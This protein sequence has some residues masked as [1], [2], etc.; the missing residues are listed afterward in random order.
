MAPPVAHRGVQPVADR[1]PRSSGSLVDFARDPIACMRRLYE[2]HG[3]LAVLEEGSQRLVFVFSPEL[4]QQVLSDPD[5]FYAHFFAIRGPK[6]SSQRKLTTGLL[7][8]NGEQHKRNRRLVKE[9]FS[10]RSLLT[11]YQRIAAIADDMLDAW[12]VGQTR[13]LF[14][15]MTHYML[16]VTSTILFGFD[17]ADMAV[18]IGKKIERWAAMQHDLGIGA[19]VPDDR[20]SKGYEELLEYAKEL[21]GDILEMIRLRRSE[22]ADG[23]DVLSIL[24]RTFDDQGG[25]SDDELVGQSAVLFAA[26]HMTTAHSLTWTLFLLAQHP[27]IMQE[28][29]RELAQS[30]VAQFARAEVGG[31]SST[32]LDRV[33]K[34]S[35][36]ILP[37]S[38][39]SQRVN[40]RAVRLGSLELKRGT[41]IIWSPYI[42]HHR[43]DLYPS[44]ERFLPS[45][46]ETIRPSA[47]EYL[48]FGG[49]PR[50]CIGGPL[51]M[52]VLKTTLPRVLLRYRL[53]IE[54][55]AEINGRVISTMLTP[56]TPVPTQIHA[57][58]GNYVASPIRGN[59]HEMV[60][61]SA[62]CG[63]RV[64]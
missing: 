25:L 15:E 46:W 16:R 20:F 35:M 6:R 36:R 29:A 55:G 12:R 9:P 32:L 1:E 24:V 3:D 47:Y 26:A 5:T 45:R 48:P 18:R 64:N 60:E 28:L 37:A 41:A 62:E 14:V 44:P 61:L 57:P 56:T 63:V 43:V 39:Y 10:K 21:E 51:A 27:Q 50:L 7:G 31:E 38:S 17:R 40:E 59:I 4:N 54:P 2:E 33:I 13:D 58:D 42:T 22:N 53:Q 49:G 52:M 19:L 11:Y 30:D 34:E 23:E 8:M